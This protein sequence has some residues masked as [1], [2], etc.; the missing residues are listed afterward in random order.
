MIR[1]FLGDESGYSLVEVIVSVML[2]SV[3]II[4]MVGMFDA[5]LR[6]AVTGSNYDQARTLANSSMENIKVLPY[7]KTNPSGVDDSVVEIFDP[8]SEDSCP[9][10]LPAGF[11]CEVE[12]KF[13]DAA[14]TPSSFQDAP[15]TS[16]MVVKVRTGWGGAAN[17]IEITGLVTR[18]K[19]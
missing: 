13:S 1:K 16:Q 17:K 19:P 2:L 7:T 11:S 8:A 3:A 18:S 15:Q 14:L 4:P 5:G 12:T 10:S 9:V 6:A